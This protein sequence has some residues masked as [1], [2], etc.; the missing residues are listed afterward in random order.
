MLELLFGAGLINHINMT[1]LR[2]FPITF[3]IQVC[4]SF[5]RSKQVAIIAS[6]TN[7]SVHIKILGNFL[8]ISTENLLVDNGIISRM[9]IPVVIE[10][11]GLKKFL[12]ERHI[13]LPTWAANRMD[14]N[15]F[16][17]IWCIFNGQ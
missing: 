7:T 9:I 5:K 14:L 1:V 10:Q 11:R 2:K 6:L 8:I 3:M 15:S 12:Q 16:I 4:I 13:K 17:S